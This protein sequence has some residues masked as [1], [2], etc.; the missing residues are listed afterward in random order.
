VSKL[1]NGYP[2]F[3]NCLVNNNRTMTLALS[4]GKNRHLPG[5]RR[6]RWP[7]LT[8]KVNFKVSGTQMAGWLET[9]CALRIMHCCSACLD[10]LRSVGLRALI[11]R[12]RKGYGCIG[13]RCVA[14]VSIALMLVSI[15]AM[16]GLP[17]A[18]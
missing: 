13:R 10:R 7:Q 2:Q 15:A 5:D 14:R 16:M 1:R 6:C 9:L 4:S 8:G 3:H 18:T 17:V 11:P 12:G